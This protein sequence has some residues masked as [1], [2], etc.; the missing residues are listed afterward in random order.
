MQ[1]REEAWLAI[2]NVCCVTKRF[3]GQTL[4]AV[5]DDVAAAGWMVEAERLG[6][7][8]I[9]SPLAMLDAELDW[10]CPVHAA[11]AVEDAE[12]QRRA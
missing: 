6:A 11:K 2:C 10:L 9:S 5:C 7:M 1:R 4:A 3:T 12:R 8:T